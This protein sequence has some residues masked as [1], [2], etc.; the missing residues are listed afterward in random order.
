MRRRRVFGADREQRLEGLAI[1][2]AHDAHPLLVAGVQRQDAVGRGPEGPLGAGGY[3][4]PV[5]S[6]T[7]PNSSYTFT[8]ASTM[9]AECTPTQRLTSSSNQ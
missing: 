6:L 9:I 3:L 4:P 7:S 1:L 2:G 8:S 5:S